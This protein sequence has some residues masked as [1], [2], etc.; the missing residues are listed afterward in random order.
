MRVQLIFTALLAALAR[1]SGQETSDD[2]R[3]ASLFK[4]GD[5]WLSLPEVFSNLDFDADS[6]PA[7]EDDI[8][9][10]MK[11][12]GTRYW[13]RIYI[14][15]WPQTIQFFRAHFGIEPPFGRKTFVFAEPRDACTEFVN[16][17]QLTADHVLLVRRGNCTFGSKAKNAMKTLASAMVVINNEPGLD[18]L[19]GPDAHDIEFSVT[20]IPEPDG[21]LLERAY[22]AGPPEGGFGRLLEGYLVPMNCANSGACQP[23]TFEEAREI[24]VLSEGGA[25]RVHK[26]SG[27]VDGSIIIEYMLSFFGSKVTHDSLPHRVVVPEPADA[28]SPLIGDFSG[29][30]VLVRRGNC[31]FFKKAEHIQAA[32][33]AATIIGNTQPVILR[34][35]VEPRWKGLNISIPVVM[36]SDR[37]YGLLLARLDAKVSL[38]EMKNVTASWELLEKLYNGEGWPRSEEYITKLHKEL[39]AQHKDFPDRLE[40][41]G[42]AFKK[43]MERVPKVDKEL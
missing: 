9:G 8:P 17:D 42:D 11:L 41:L 40:A 26:A 4:A 25:L 12:R 32:G 16:A 21:T 35:G 43:K 31:P 13:G 22:D 30:F 34:M 10:Q 24:K 37:G 5:E 19:H 28:C 7:A 29:A 2:G 15:G 6:T 27:E 38:L 33:G 23:A 39:L 14:D 18:H 36:T 3:K 1:G 20:S